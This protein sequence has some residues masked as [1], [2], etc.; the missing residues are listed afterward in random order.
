MIKIT[1]IHEGDPV[2][3]LR[4]EG[5]I[6]GKTADELDT[7]CGAILTRG[8]PLRLDLAGVGFVDAEGARLV[9]RL[10]TRGAVVVGCSPL[11][12]ELLRASAEDA[13]PDD[14]VSAADANPDAL[15]LERIRRGDD[16]AF[17]TVVRTYGGR[18]L[19]VARRMLR[20]DD[21]AQDAVQEAFVS[22][23]KALDRFQA[24]AKLSTW[25][26]RIVVNACLMRLRSR[27]RAR[28]D[29]L[30][31]LLPRFDEDGAWAAE[32]PQWDGPADLVERSETRE[33]VRRCIDRLPDAYRT[34]LLLRDVEEL[35]TDEAAAALG[36]T[37]SAIKT[38][39]HRAR[40]ALR[41]LLEQHLGA[42]DRSERAVG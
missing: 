12:T 4:V 30:D 6:I 35:D 8:E 17:E 20:S 32:V 23:F 15:L 1:T 21:D 40:Q 3:R 18:M 2:T 24:Q 36:T 25:L 29:S 22:A 9:A 31:E 5:R 11:V 33:L 19:A 26:H 37:A 13:A 34:V 38:R 28:E 14:G 7:A 42:P 41:T 16:A 10:G 27:R 39:L